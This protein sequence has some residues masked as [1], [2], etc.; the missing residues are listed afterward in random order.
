M[1]KVIKIEG[2]GRYNDVSPFILNENDDLDLQIDFLRKLRGQYFIH[3]SLNEKTKTFNLEHTNRI[4]LDSQYLEAGI[5]NAKLSLV[6][7]GQVYREWRIEPLIIKQL[8][9]GKQFECEQSFTNFNKRL[10]NCEKAILEL[11]NLIKKQGGLL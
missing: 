6:F 11:T 8:D 9:D 2:I 5:L 1:K 3:F 10:S 4:N 7:N